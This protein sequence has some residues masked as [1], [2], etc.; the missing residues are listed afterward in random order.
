MEHR[1]GR[2]GPRAWLRWRQ[3]RYGRPSLLPALVEPQPTVVR[4]FVP[5][6]AERII[7][8]IMAQGDPNE[9]NSNRQIVEMHPGQQTPSV[10]QIDQSS[11][12]GEMKRIGRDDSSSGQIRRYAERQAGRDAS[13]IQSLYASN[14]LIFLQRDS[15][16]SWNTNRAKNDIWN[17]IYRDDTSP[18]ARE[19]KDLI[20]A[21]LLEYDRVFQGRM[22]EYQLESIDDIHTS[23]IRQTAMQDSITFPESVRRRDETKFH[24][25]DLGVIRVLLE[26]GIDP[27]D[28]VDR[29]TEIHALADEYDKYFA[30]P[31]KGVKWPND[32]EPFPELAI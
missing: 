8:I 21:Y 3:R 25:R 11:D 1:Y 9:E 27:E 15:L 7:F 30:N 32:L 17:K 14:Q 29:L 13:K 4:V 5:A 20:S 22:R 10:L 31:R 24:Q 6:N 26:L 2:H 19:E 23:N 12:T 16:S 28:A 18:T